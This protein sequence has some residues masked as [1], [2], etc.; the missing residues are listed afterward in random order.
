MKLQRGDGIPE[1]CLTVGDNGGNDFSVLVITGAQ[2][3]WM[4]RTGEIDHPEVR[5]LYEGN[6]DLR[7][8]LGFLAWLERWAPE[9]LGVELPGAQ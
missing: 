5:D 2:R 4:W 8:P 7:T 9:R 6:G 3:G 1:G